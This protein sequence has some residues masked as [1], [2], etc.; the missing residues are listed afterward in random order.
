MHG[1][2]HRHD[3]LT[4]G[5]DRESGLAQPDRGR[6]SERGD[7]LVE[8]LLATVIIAITVAALLGALIQSVRGS[9]VHRSLATVDT[10]LKSFAE[11]AKYDIQL[12]PASGGSG[13]SFIDCATAYRVL[14]TP[15]PSSGPANTA[16][17]VFGTGYAPNSGLS[18][19]MIGSS[20]VPSVTS[21]GTSDG[22]G[23]LA[24]TFTIPSGLT[25]GQGYPIKVTDAS[26]DTATS[27]DSFVFTS[28]AP[29]VAASPLAAYTVG[30]TSIQWWN[31]STQVFD[32]STGTCA[33][34]DRSGIQSITVTAK[35]ADNSSGT[36]TFTAI[37]PATTAPA[38]TSLS[39]ATFTAGTAGSFTVASTGFPAA[40]LS[41]SGTLP[42][43]VSFID[44]GNGKATLAGTPAAGTGG[45]YN[46]TITATSSAGSATQT[47][48]LTVNQP[49]AITS[50]NNTNFT[51]GAAGSFTV[52]TSGFPP[53]AL[54]GSGALPSGVTFTDNHNGTATL[55]GTPAAGTTG[56]HPLTIQATNTA[57]STSQ[58]FTLAVNQAPAVTS[59][60]TT[61]FTVGT[62]GTF[63]VTAT[64]TPTPTLSESG[65]L[66][67]GVTF[68][69]ATGVLAGTPAAGTGGTYTITFT[70][71]NGVNPNATQTFTLTVNQAPAI[72]SAN[73]TSFTHGQ[74]GTFTVTAT[75][76]P[77]PTL[78]ES[79]KLPKGVSFNAAT[80]VLSGTPTQAG[81]FSVTFTAS[82]GINPNDTQNF[83][84]TVN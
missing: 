73:T 6:G 26:N 84:L 1:Q 54:T 21:G 18:V 28:G 82:N 56:T 80:G 79:G 14:G 15:S 60:N 55:A 63:T 13:P 44:N 38:I 68:N 30:I 8:V 81:T 75:G 27:T 32:P 51:V 10:V 7:T 46:L 2:R 59:A 40:A 58:T 47:F 9:V 33:P 69:P 66:P 16:V 61:T 31:S 4:M 42:A 70:A 45:T 78:S 39:S 41:E 5:D 11:S 62:A 17:T 72:T 35:A 67:S 25:P 65:A 37:N 76:F 36:V 77:N 49:P 74:A 53:P 3:R 20:A 29:S 50:A 19:S 83:T 64:G 71:T 34:G 48:T 43:G 24:L 23:N 22:N 57:G 52:T 12:R